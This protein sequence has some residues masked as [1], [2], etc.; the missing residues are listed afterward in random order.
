MVSAI[1][2]TL[3]TWYGSSELHSFWLLQ[4]DVIHI[5]AINGGTGVIRTMLACSDPQ[6]KEIVKALN[7]AEHPEN[8]FIIR[9]LPGDHLFVKTERVE[10]LKAKIKEYADS[11][12]FEAPTGKDQ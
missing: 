10:I 2:G 11:L 4:V 6:L 12:H 8:R 9:D 5:I 1:Q 3:I 7:A